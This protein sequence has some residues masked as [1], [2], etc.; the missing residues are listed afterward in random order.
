MPCRKLLGA[1]IVTPRLLI[2]T[3]IILISSSVGDLSVTGGFCWDATA[4]HRHHHHP[5]HHSSHACVAHL[6]SGS[7]GGLSV[8]GGSCV[9]TPRLRLRDWLR[10]LWLRSG[11]LQ[12]HNFHNDHTEAPLLRD[13]CCCSVLM[14]AFNPGSGLMACLPACCLITL[15]TRPH[16]SP[17]PRHHNTQNSLLPWQNSKEIV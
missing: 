14:L 3:I 10:W 12:P 2:I 7:V 6:I 1:P 16:T 8:T 17:T 5:H 11:R 15:D 4:P 9:V 13:L